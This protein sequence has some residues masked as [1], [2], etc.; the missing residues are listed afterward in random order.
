LS[1]INVMCGK[2]SMQNDFSCMHSSNIYHQFGQIE[3]LSDG[4]LK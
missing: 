4:V 1:T 3:L 2:A